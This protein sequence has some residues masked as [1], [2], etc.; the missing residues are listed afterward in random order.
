[1]PG[2]HGSAAAVAEA[3]CEH[4][5]QP[6]HSCAGTAAPLARC[7]AIWPGLTRGHAP[8]QVGCEAGGPGGAAVSITALA[9]CS[10][11][12]HQ[13]LVRGKKRAGFEFEVTLKWRAALP[14]GGGGCGGGEGERWVEG[15][16]R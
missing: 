6:C 16:V 15:T 9:S 3:G 1:M 7:A 8:L 5:R 10:G 11:E 2:G 12:A 14:G 13:W 4:G